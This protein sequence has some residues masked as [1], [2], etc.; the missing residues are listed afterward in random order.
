ME[1]TALVLDPAKFAMLRQMKGYTQRSLAERSDFKQSYIARI[2][3][4][5]VSPGPENIKRLADALEVDVLAITTVRA[6][7]QKAAAR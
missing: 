6:R 3:T 2:E 7:P 4:S 1:T 5:R